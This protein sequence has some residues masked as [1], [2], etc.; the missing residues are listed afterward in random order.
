MKKGGISE[1]RGFTLVELLVVIAIIAILIAILLPVLTKV[2]QQAIQLQ[3]QSNLHQLG[4]AMTAYT[5][6]FGVFPLVS[7]WPPKTTSL[8]GY[9][10]AWPTQLRKILR[11][12]QRV[13]YCPAQDSECQWKPDAPGEVAYADEFDTQFG[14]EVGER[15]LL[16][17]AWNQ[18]EGARG[19]F[20]SYGCN[21]AGRWGDITNIQPPTGRGMG[22]FV[23]DGREWWKDTRSRQ[24][25]S[26]RSPAEFILMGDTTADGLN[27]FDIFAGAYIDRLT[28]GATLS[29]APATVHRGG[30][31]ILFCDGHVQWYL[32][33]DLVCRTPL[34]A[35]DAAK[36][37][38]WNADNQPARDWP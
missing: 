33:A 29:A 7:F 6:Q 32:Q 1:R 8:G 23:W 5:Q 18:Q 14:Y 15:L 10:M 20:F 28:S 36:Q 31:N 25:T 12:N 24:V 34:V 4:V 19:T 2:R 21:V 27:D 35:E 13:F 37:R 38:M 11:G 22:S 17:G 30:A 9:G 26:I 16:N 3:C